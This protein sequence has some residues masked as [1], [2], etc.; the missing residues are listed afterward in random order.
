MAMLAAAAVP[1][2]IVGLTMEDQLSA[3]F[4]G[5]LTLVGAMHLNGEE[6]LIN[7]L[8]LSGYD[9]EQVKS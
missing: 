5:N 1:V 3:L 9:I 8:Q 7:Q 2:V 4:E 6:G